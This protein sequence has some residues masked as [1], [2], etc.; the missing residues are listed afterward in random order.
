MATTDAQ[1]ARLRRD[2]GT[3]ATSLPDD[4]IDD[5]FDEAAETYSDGATAA[6]YT[7][8][9]VLQ[10]ILADSAKLVNYRQNE[11]QENMSD[12]FKHV[13]ALLN[14]WEEKTDEAA[15]AAASSSGAA[16]FG[17]VRRKPAKVREYPGVY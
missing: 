4:D 6:A 15:T 3:N 12:V 9:L 1:K 10:G 16:R 8:V 7:R 14:V 13:Q 17:S 11:S 5:I 2:T